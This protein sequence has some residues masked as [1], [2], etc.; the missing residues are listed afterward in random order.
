MSKGAEGALV[1]WSPFPIVELL[2]NR[3]H[4]FIDL[5]NV[6]ESIEKAYFKKYFNI[7]QSSPSSAINFALESSMIHMWSIVT[8]FCERFNHNIY[9][10]YPR[11]ANVT[12]INSVCI[13]LQISVLQNH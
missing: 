11:D 12:A 5:T 8:G 7:T 3:H 2:R 1:G 6:T 13:T 9:M 10:M 4:Y